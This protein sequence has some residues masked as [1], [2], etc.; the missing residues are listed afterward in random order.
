MNERG[1]GSRDA[2]GVGGG[3]RDRREMFLAE[4]SRL[5]PPPSRDG[6]ETRRVRR[7]RGIHGTRTGGID[8]QLDPAAAGNYASAAAS[9]VLGLPFL[10]DLLCGTRLTSLRLL[11]PGD[12][13]RLC[14]L[15]VQVL[16]YLRKVFPGN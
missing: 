10:H 1:G 15:P 2:Y 3:G 9:L 8:T 5:E 4:N 11:V 14:V 7:F 13:S 12:G 16:L 6:R